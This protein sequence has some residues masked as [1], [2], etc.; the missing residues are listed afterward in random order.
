M[1]F[2]LSTGRY[3]LMY[4]EQ[5]SDLNLLH[6]IIKEPLHFMID[7]FKLKFFSGLDGELADRA[8]NHLVIQYIPVLI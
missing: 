6:I 8:Q 5:V 7:K 2:L 3:Q 4:Y 1:L